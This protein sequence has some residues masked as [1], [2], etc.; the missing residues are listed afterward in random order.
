MAA[1]SVGSPAGPRG[2]CACG[3][4]ASREAAAK[5]AITEAMD[6]TERFISQRNWY[7]TKDRNNPTAMEKAKTTQGGAIGPTTFSAG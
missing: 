2:G 3:G 1:G 5:T 6:E 4:A 7:P